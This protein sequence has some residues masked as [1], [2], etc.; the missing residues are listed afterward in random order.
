MDYSKHTATDLMMTDSFRA[1]VNQ[2]DKESC[3]FWDTLLQQQPQLLPVAKEASFVLLQLQHIKTVDSAPEMETVKANIDL[4]LDSRSRV[5]RRTGRVRLL[6][7]T[8]AAAILVLMAGFALF[9]Y[10]QE[11]TITA[12]FARTSEVVLPDGSKVILN[13]NSAVSFKKHWLGWKHREVWLQGEAFFKVTSKPQG[14]H[15]K[16]VVHASALDVAVVG[17]QFNVYNRRNNV[18]VVLKEGKVIASGTGAAANAGQLKMHPGQM[19][20]LQN[21]SMQLTEVDA[22]AYISWMSNRLVFA[23]M[24]LHK[25]AQVLEDNY[26]YTVIW[27]NKSMMDSTF[28]GSCPS[29]NIQILTAAISAVYNRKVSITGNSVTFE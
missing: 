6:R 2:S 18:N 27:K 17:T 15:P 23:N 28:T 3:A 10:T 8:A 19:V 29:D 7:M 5:M 26:G 25:V 4:L 21:N 20:A 1:W 11:E 22:A 24:P 12:G 16:F 14:Y 13:A 9:Y